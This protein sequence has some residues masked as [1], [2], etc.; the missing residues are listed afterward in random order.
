MF[1]DMWLPQRE[2][3][4]LLGG[5]IFSLTTNKSQDRI[6]LRL[7]SEIVE[8][9]GCKL[10]DNPENATIRIE[11]GKTC[12]ES[13]EA[14]AIRG[15]QGALLIEGNTSK[16]VLYG[17]YAFLR[18]KL[19]GK[20]VDNVYSAPSQSIRMVDHW[21]QTD[22]SI[23]R[24]YAGASILFGTLGENTWEDPG[25]FA[26]HDQGLDP[27]RHD[28]AR[29]VAYARFLASIGLN[30]VALNN[31]NVRGLGAQLI[32][33]PFIE[34][35]KEVADLFDEFGISTYLSIF[36][37]APKH[38]GGLDTSD[39]LDPDVRAWW[40]A[41]ADDIYAMIPNFG[42]F[43]VKAD[44]EGEPGPYQ[45]GR[46]HAD[47]ANMLAEALTAHGGTVIWRAF[48][49][50]SAQDWRDRSTDRAKAAF[51]NFMQLDG[52]FADN[53]ALQ[54]KFGPIDFQ[55]CEPLNTLIGGLKH[56]NVIIEFEITAEYLG[57]QIDVNYSVPQWIHMINT[58]SGHESGVD[59][60][61]KNVIRKHAIDNK[62]TGF[63]AVQ[64][65]G[66][67]SNWTGNKLSQANF[68]GFGRMCWND[69]LTAD[70][71]LEEW[72]D[73]TFPGL[74]EDGKQIL[75]YIQSTSNHTYIDYTA[76]LGVGFMTVPHYHYGPSVN[77]Y[78]Y[79]RWGTYHFADRNGV[80]VDRTQATGSGYTAQ[81]APALEEQY[82][83]LATIPDEMLLFF[84]HVPYTHVLQSGS[85]VIQHIY[86]T[87]FRGFDT[88]K[89]YISQ[90]AQIQGKIST[91]DF[92]NVAERLERQLNNAMEWRDQVN[93]FFWR[94][95]GIPDE[96]GRLIHS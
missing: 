80:G 39:P 60:L 19:T 94:M 12:F 4:I 20:S 49:Y 40:S 51:E 71:I 81:Y 23:E 43:L 5:E 15:Y 16:A 41:K 82:E 69:E 79:D 13:D 8:F 55:N 83:N 61:A 76:P 7:Q 35:V 90:W 50:N 42:G 1:D 63:A 54:V 77:G 44:S 56:T 91:E 67:D 46:N 58:D 21:D 65:V 89:E 14:Y 24:G 70:Q 52:M 64:S 31:V 10:V 25:S 92:E 68:Y 3:R 88:V 74:D 32:E 86:D 78:E 96:R 37:G 48:V 85:T 22:G 53:V 72:I 84:H 2:L 73:Q 34:Q 62:Y 26:V 33:H 18:L 36:F 45:Y 27:F 47:G 57:H 6:S 38:I 93:T 29:L 75:R 28:R 59:G 11:I 66:M 95:S 87:H 17:F 9:L 30:A